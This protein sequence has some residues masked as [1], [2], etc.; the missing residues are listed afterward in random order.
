MIVLM[1]TYSSMDVD[2][3]GMQEFLGIVVRPTLVHRRRTSGG[4]TSFGPS[5]ASSSTASSP[6]ATSAGTSMSHRQSADPY[7]VYSYVEGD[8]R[9]AA[10]QFRHELRQA[11][12]VASA[13]ARAARRKRSSFRRPPKI[14]SESGSQHSTST[15]ALSLT[16]PPSSGDDHDPHSSREFNS[17]GP[18]QTSLPLT[19]ALHYLRQ[20]TP[21][22]ICAPQITWPL[23]RSI[24]DS[25]PVNFMTQ[26]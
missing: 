11:R 26:S 10:K 4:P 23:P 8:D 6:S 17:V 15:S 9:E 21:I 13:P 14:Q 16:I 12:K 25:L 1:A 7:Y 3:D 22:L 19:D 2:D 18:R 5:S 24:I 20:S